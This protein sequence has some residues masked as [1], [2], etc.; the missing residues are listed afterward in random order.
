MEWKRKEDE[1]KEKKKE[2]NEGDPGSK[3]QLVPLP[4]A[5]DQPLHCQYA[6]CRSS[7]IN[8]G[9][10]LFKYS[11]VV[12][13]FKYLS[14]I[15]SNSVARCRTFAGAAL[16]GSEG[17]WEGNELAY[18]KPSCLLAWCHRAKRHSRPPARSSRSLLGQN[19]GAIHL[20]PNLNQRL[21][22]SWE[23]IGSGIVA[24]KK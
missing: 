13:R 21:R 1:M 9:R 20:P 7:F 23:S 8:H 5:L 16:V 18:F 2:E 4:A 22:G 14:A 24:L 10:T 11:G 15:F 17:G 3:L 6:A 19:L 12:F